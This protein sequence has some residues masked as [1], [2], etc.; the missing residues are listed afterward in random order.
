MAEPDPKPYL[1]Y[2]DKEMAIMGLLSTFCVLVIGLTVNSSLG[3]DRGELKNVWPYGHW[4]LLGGSFWMLVAAVLFYRQRTLLAYY[5][6]QIALCHVQGSSGDYENADTALRDSD[7]WI[8][9]FF[10]QSGFACLIAGFVNYGIALLSIIVPRLRETEAIFG[11]ALAGGIIVLGFALWNHRRLQARDE[12]PRE[13]RRI[14][15]VAKPRRR[16]KKA[17]Q[18]PN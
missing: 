3:A 15:W 13:R 18:H 16:N 5:Y 12:E 1:E 6:G 2:L 11:F 7:A 4:Y 8:T 17:M 10:Y 14:G 9:S